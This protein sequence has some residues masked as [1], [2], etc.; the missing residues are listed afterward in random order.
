MY[1]QN[2]EKDP[3][4][5]LDTKTVYGADSSLIGSEHLRHENGLKEYWDGVEQECKRRDIT[6][7]KAEIERVLRNLSEL[8]EQLQIKEADFSNHSNVGD[9]VEGFGEDLG[10]NSDG[11]PVCGDNNSSSDFGS[12]YNYVGNFAEDFGD[13]LGGDSDR[14][15]VDENT[16]DTL[17]GIVGT[18]NSQRKINRKRRDAQRNVNYNVGPSSKRRRK[19]KPT[20]SPSPSPQPPSS[21]QLPPQSP[22]SLLLSSPQISLPPLPIPPHRDRICNLIVGL[23]KDEVM[24]D[25]APGVKRRWVE[26]IEKN[27][28]IMYHGLVPK[29]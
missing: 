24:V 26:E 14:G 3:E 18:Q 23:L 11:G 22:I 10:G 28:N 16:S 21:P 5:I 9:F 4:F 15:S 1:R 27:I 12:N 29:L 2:G 7:H 17:S 20:P 6:N 19:N 25:S 8:N 13:D